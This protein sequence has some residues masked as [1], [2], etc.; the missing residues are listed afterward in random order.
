MNHHS[1]SIEDGASACGSVNTVRR[2]GNKV[3]RPTGNWSPAVHRLLCHLAEREFDFSPRVLGV[4]S[5]SGTEQLSF[6]DGEAAMRPW[7][8][9]LRDE[10]GIVEIGRMLRAYH[11]AVSR[12]VP[13]PGSP[14]RVPKVNWQSGMIIRHGDLG[15]WNM[16]WES[17]RLVG[18]IDWDF[19]EPGYPID[20][21]AQAAWYCVPMRPDKGCHEAGIDPDQRKARL[22]A[23]STAHGTEPTVV[24]EAL[25]RLQESEMNRTK[26]YGEAGLEPWKSFL[27]RGDIDE[28]RSEMIWLEDW[29]KNA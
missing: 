24:T 1:R 8:D 22:A 18:L 2:Q 11:V 7:P 17:E 16:V 13:K 27:H 6:I 20:D 5:D 19:A 21:L 4:D 15:P 25:I 28:M 29:M 12:Y 3:I 23:L 9:C 14:W 10:A 26:S